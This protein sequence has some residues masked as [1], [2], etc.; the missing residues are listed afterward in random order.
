VISQIAKMKIVIVLGLL[1]VA[2]V[3]C[4]PAPGDEV[5]LIDIPKKND[6]G[7][8]FDD[9][10]DDDSSFFP[11]H[12]D[13]KGLLNSFQDVF[14]GFS[15]N[16]HDLF[17]T[18]EGEGNTTSTVKVI[19]NRKVVINETTYHR[20]TPYGTQFVKVHRVSVHPLDQNDTATAAGSSEFSPEVDEASNQIPRDDEVIQRSGKLKGTDVI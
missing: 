5:E 10:D 20:D 6:T 15:T 17:S 19:D 16:L 13:F 12:F 11:F 18:A 4:K 3:S 14:R 9:Y 1:L 2:S 7:F 8:G